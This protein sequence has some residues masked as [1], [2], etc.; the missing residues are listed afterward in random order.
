MPRRKSTSRRTKKGDRRGAPAPQL[1]AP[2]PTLALPDDDAGSYASDD[3]VAH[4]APDAAI[5]A[6]A[7]AA[8]AARTVEPADLST[9]AGLDAPKEAV[10]LV[11]AAALTLAA[12]GGAGVP[13]YVR[14]PAVVEFVEADAAG[15]DSLRALDCGRGGLQAPRAPGSWTRRRRL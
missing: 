2:T 15:V 7:H 9:L 8:A 5:K 13:G 14:W 11:A 12:G 6:A 3:D 4:S 1:G 10:A